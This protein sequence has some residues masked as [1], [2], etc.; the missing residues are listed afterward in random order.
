[1]LTLMGC[2]Q[3]ARLVVAKAIKQVDAELAKIGN[4]HAY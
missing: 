3:R 2:A 1:M 4:T